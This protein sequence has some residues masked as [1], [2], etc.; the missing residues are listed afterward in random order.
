MRDEGAKRKKSL[1]SQA[2]DHHLMFEKTNKKN[3]REDLC[4]LAPAKAKA[5]HF[6]LDGGPGEHTWRCLTRATAADEE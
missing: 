4:Q 1:E 3:E 2:R 6:S 5:P